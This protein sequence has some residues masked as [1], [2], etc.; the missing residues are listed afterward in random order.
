[1]VTN[2]YNL[3]LNS[4]AIYSIYR[5]IIFYPLLAIYPICLKREELEN[6]KAPTIPIGIGSRGFVTFGIS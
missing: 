1:M 4:K 6:N 2:T 5:I 3:G